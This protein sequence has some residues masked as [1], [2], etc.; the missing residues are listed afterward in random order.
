MRV[1]R[2]LLWILLISVF[3]YGIFAGLGGDTYIDEYGSGRVINII[4]GV[5]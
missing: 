4:E 5:F 2:A 1:I 3:L